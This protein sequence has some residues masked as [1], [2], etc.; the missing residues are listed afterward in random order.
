VSSRSDIL[1]HLEPVGSPLA[2]PRVTGVP[3]RSLD[4]ADFR[5]LIASAQDDPRLTNR[6]VTVANTIVLTPEQQ[7]RLERAADAALA[8][9]ART[10]LVLLDARPLR[11]DVQ[12]REVSEEVRADG[13]F[14]R[15]LTDI[16]TVIVSRDESTADEEPAHNLLLRRLSGAARAAAISGL[17]IINGAGPSPSSSKSQDTGE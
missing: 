1:R 17:F 7:S 6:P 15:I 13:D 9:D 8:H 3:R 11:L 4:E 16:D 14:D 5:S 10:A 2:A 12:A